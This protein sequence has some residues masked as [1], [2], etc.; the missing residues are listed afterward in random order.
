VGFGPT[1]PL[2]DVPNVTAHASTANVLTSYY[3]IW[4]YSYIF[5]LNA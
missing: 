5:T 2:L 3:L 4:H 1:V